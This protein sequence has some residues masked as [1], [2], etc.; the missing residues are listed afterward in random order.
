MLNKDALIEWTWI[1]L[2]FTNCPD[3]WEDT[4]IVDIINGYNGNCHTNEGKALT[5]SEVRS[6][7]Y[8]TEEE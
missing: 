1:N 3:T 5:Y 6:M 7:F 4:Y 2:E 8:E